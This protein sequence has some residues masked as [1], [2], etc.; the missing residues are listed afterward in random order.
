MKRLASYV[1]LILIAALLA[2]CFGGAPEPTAN[3]APTNTPIPPTATVVP[4]TD[5]P[6]PP[7]DTPVPPTDTPVP[8]PPHRADARAY[9]DTGTDSGANRHDGAFPGAY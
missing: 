6:V 3:A 4:P 7:T 5:T 1:T 8:P 9:G 2:S